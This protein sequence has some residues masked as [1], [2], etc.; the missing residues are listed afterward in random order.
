MKFYLIFL[1]LLQNLHHTEVEKL[2]RK[3]VSLDFILFQTK[4]KECQEELD[5]KE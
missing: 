1:V 2:N 3:R 4:N 5:P